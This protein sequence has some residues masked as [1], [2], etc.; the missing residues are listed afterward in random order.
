MGRILSLFSVS[1][2]A[3]LQLNIRLALTSVIAVPLLVAISILF[4]RKVSAAYEAMQEQEAVV[5][6][7]LQENLTGM[8]VVRAA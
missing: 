3:L 4:F 5:S 6:T 1:L 7:T 8:R 2:V